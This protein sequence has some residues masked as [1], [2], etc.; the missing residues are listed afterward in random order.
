[1]VQI[2]IVK[3]LGH[4][5]LFLNALS[6][7][8]AFKGIFETFISINDVQGQGSLNKNTETKQKTPPI[9]TTPHPQLTLQTLACI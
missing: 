4:F 5:N 3:D 8:T 2:R 6:E 9:R 7:I 1:M